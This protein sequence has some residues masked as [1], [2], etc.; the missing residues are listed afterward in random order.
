MSHEEVVRKL[1]QEC[2]SPVMKQETE[3]GPTSS[4][5][6]FLLLHSGK[7]EEWDAGEDRAERWPLQDQRIS[8]ST[9]SERRSRTNSFSPPDKCESNGGTAASGAKI[10][11]DQHTSAAK[12]REP[13]I[14][15]YLYTEIR[16][17]Y[18]LGNDEQR[19]MERR[20]KFYIFLKIPVQL[21]K[22]LM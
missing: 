11:T 3:A 6:S 12:M 7:Q 15:D 9:P 14:L 21:E 16:R 22:V 13:T 20:E 4:E 19:Y 1:V 18:D 2:S 8:S 17:G 10:T 5:T